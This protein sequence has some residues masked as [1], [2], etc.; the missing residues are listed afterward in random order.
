MHNFIKQIFLVTI[1]IS[2]A[3]NVFSEPPIKWEDR[4]IPLPKKMNIKSSGYFSRNDIFLKLPPDL[5]APELLTAGNILSKFCRGTADKAI[6]TIELG[7][8][9]K[10]D[11]SSDIHS[12]LKALPNS[13][14]A[15]AITSDFNHKLI[16]IIANTPVGLLYGARSLNMLIKG[17]Q[18]IKTKNKILIPEVE[19]IDWPDVKL[20]GAWGNYGNWSPKWWNFWKLNCI[21]VNSYF[22]LT[23][24]GKVNIFPYKELNK[25][26]RENGVMLIN[27][28]THLASL[29]KQIR[30]YKTF[31]GAPNPYL[32][33]LR[34]QKTGKGCYKNNYGICCSNPLTI[35]LLTDGMLQIAQT[36]SSP[37]KNICVWLTEAYERCHCDKCKGMPSWKTEIP[38]I[39]KAFNQIKSK[40]PNSKLSIWLSQGSFKYNTSAELMSSIP[41]WVNVIYYSGSK[42]Y[43]AKKKPM[44]FKELEKFC[45]EGGNIGVV[46]TVANSW[47]AVMP[48]S[49]PQLIK[50]RADEF[51]EKNISSVFCYPV[52]SR[53]MYEFNMIAMAEWLW[54]N[55]GRGIKDF[56]RAYANITGIKNPE[57]YVEWITFAGEAGW[58]IGDCNLFGNLMY[59]PRVG[60]GHKVSFD[61]RFKE[62]TIFKKTNELDRMVSI[63][64]KALA[65]AR[66][67]GNQQMINESKWTLAAL[68]FINNF[69][70]VKKILEAKNINENKI[71]ELNKKLAN[72]DILALTCATVLDDWSKCF[73]GSYKGWKPNIPGDKPLI[74]NMCGAPSRLG[75]L[76][77]RILQSA[78]FMYNYARELYGDKIK[79]VLILSPVA[80]PVASQFKQ[81]G[82][83]I[84]I[85]FDM[86][87]ALKGQHGYFELSAAYFTKI[88]NT[89]LGVISGTLK[90]KFPDGKIK[91]IVLSRSNMFYSKSF[92]KIPKAPIGT[93]YQLSCVLRKA[94]GKVLNQKQ[95]EKLITL[96]KVYQ[97]NN[98]PFSVFRI[99]K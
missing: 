68:E 66:K 81:N 41:K 60:I 96:R 14:Q 29:A 56:S 43:T 1:M 30:K 93:R 13:E 15:Y 78:D 73:L 28:I 50:Y 63:A 40:Y 57:L 17:N 6:L 65:L 62:T 71:K 37:Q 97:N 24:S 98:L 10:P 85:S 18:W 25:L 35:K 70:G 19:I 53:H 80:I 54:N 3:G 84:A 74:R 79:R 72:L 61:H 36:Q 76:S 58:A 89:S 95:V 92:F 26:C 31:S 8:N 46:P 82:N 2:I 86:S 55:K 77:T 32:A 42:T 51:V 9:N 7:L 52:P 12:K 11:V 23:A 4:I 91:R 67:S 44:I 88:M 64:R 33:C 20:R 87:K 34:K 59:D 47:F 39:L 75:L 16:R 83:N 90:M 99:K 38:A 27:H 45:K 22:K 49:S 21:E 48:L 69:R 94:K 5:K